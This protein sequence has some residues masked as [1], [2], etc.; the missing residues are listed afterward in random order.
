MAERFAYYGISSNL[1]SYLTGS[2]HQSTAAAAENV[3]AWLGAISM[4]PLNCF[5]ILLSIIHLQTIVDK[6]PSNYLGSPS[7]VVGHLDPIK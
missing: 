3:N 2:L 1:I 7:P 4:L 6:L 5:C